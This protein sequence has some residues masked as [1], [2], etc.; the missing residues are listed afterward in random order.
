MG[1]KGNKMRR[2]VTYLVIA[3][4]AI[5]LLVGM[6]RAASVRGRKAVIS[7]GRF[8]REQEPAAI[9]PAKKAKSRVKT[10]K[11][12]LDIQNAFIHVAEKAGRSVVAI[13]TERT[14][15]VSVPRPSFRFKRFG[16]RSPFGGEDPFEKFFEDFFGEI[17][18]REFKQQGLGSGFIIDKKGYILT[19]HHVVE[20]ADKITVTLP[21]ERSFQGTVKGQDPRRDLAIIKIKAKNLP[22]AELGNSDLVQTGEWAVALGNPFG[23]II[24]SP[25]PTVTVGVISALHRRI[26]APGGERGYL[27]MIQTDAAINPGNSGGPLCDLSGRVIGINVAIFSTSGGY[28]GVGFAIPINSAKDILKDLKEGKEIAYGWLGV[29]IQDITPE[30]AEYFNLE[31]RKGA[32]VS[33]VISGAPAEEA[34]MQAGDIIVA[35]NGKKVDKLQDLLRVVADA[36]VGRPA[37]VEV[38]RDRVR[39]TLEV[40]IGK[41]PSTIELE[42]GKAFETPEEIKEWRGMKVAGITDNI[43]REL[44]ITDKEGVV[45]SDVDPASPSYDAGLRVGDVIREINKTK[46]TNTADYEKVAGEARGLTLVRT[47][48]GYFTVREDEE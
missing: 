33:E 2:I 39:K 38:I 22:V 45:V 7:E 4:I 31:E 8:A 20:G 3:L 48:R 17:P 25:K 27:D 26:P 23:H 42:G 41:R 5:G 37:R 21:D 12:E 46:I 35:F 9:R 24:Q 15:K 19:N 6:I 32:L 1:R 44:G 30:I 29:T 14:H 10:L 36:K 28:Q 11:G 13:S 18:K 34:G 43:A 16:G 40:V 47:D